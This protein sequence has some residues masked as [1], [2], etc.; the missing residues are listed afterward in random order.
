MQPTQQ[1]YLSR[2]GQNKQNAEMFTS[3]NNIESEYA[4]LFSLTPRGEH[5]AEI[6]GEYIEKNGI[7]QPVWLTSDKER[8]IYTAEIASKKTRMD[9]DFYIRE[10]L[11]E[12]QTQEQEIKEREYRKGDSE[13]QKILND[14]TLISQKDLATKV[15]SEIINVGKLNPLRPLIVIGHI[16]TNEALLEDIGV[17]SKYSAMG[18]CSLFRVERKGD[19][20]IP[21]EH[22]SNKQLERLL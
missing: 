8:T 15:K 1:I 14:Q 6:L 19:T 4:D 10:N 20:L 7:G 22:L 18:N 11:N 3:G 17:N 9:D 13:Y 5:E 12:H 21:K 16:G 2:H